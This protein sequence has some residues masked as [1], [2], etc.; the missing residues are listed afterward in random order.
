MGRLQEYD[1]LSAIEALKSLAH[2]LGKQGLSKRDADS[3]PYT[4]SSTTCIRLFGSWAK[5]LEAAKLLNGNVILKQAIEQANKPHINHVPK[6]PT[7]SLVTQPEEKLE[8]KKIFN[9]IDNTQ[10][11]F[12]WTGTNTNTFKIGY[13]EFILETPYDDEFIF[14]SKRE[15][16]QNHYINQRKICAHED[17]VVPFRDFLREYIKLFGWIFPQ[18]PTQ[19][20]L[21]NLINKLKNLEGVS[22][23]ST[24]TGMS[25][26]RGW[27]RSIWA[28][29]VGRAL[30]PI[31]AFEDDK[32]CDMILSYRFGLGNSQDYHYTF[33]GVSVD[34]QE[35]FDVSFKQIRRGLEV[36]KHVV[37]TFKPL[38]AKWILQKYATPDSVVWDPCAGFGGRLLGFLATCPNGRY[39]ACEPNG[40]TWKELT[41]LA[42]T[43]KAKNVEIH[44][45][46]LE[47]FTFEDGFAD[48]VFTCPPYQN[49]EI[50]CNDLNQ[51]GTRYATVQAWEH[52][53]M[54]K[55]MSQ[56]YKALKR[57]G[58]AVIVFDQ[59]N[60]VSCIK[61]AMRAGFTILPSHDLVNTA[62]HL[63]RRQNIETALCF[64]KP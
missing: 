41:A 22:N 29:S 3:D 44:Q 60:S 4:P 5:A 26:I 42:T 11:S 27:F 24:V 52:D 18:K 17:F 49:K 19:A 32:L 59:N 9:N 10:L 61:A 28:C 50:Y 57:G 58:K 51:A 1:N 54:D 15:I 30:A 6:T 37:S 23:T 13:K 46:A 36:N 55:L 34:C 45:T 7:I 63:T 21:C 62:T 20:Q 33:D 48:L 39:V 16:W 38:L 12:S 31:H 64:L 2:R 53:F 40:A 43:L 8:S 14:F 56:A 35:L 25:E 47:D